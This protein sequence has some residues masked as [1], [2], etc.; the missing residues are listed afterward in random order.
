ML[1]CILY[2]QLLSTVGS[3]TSDVSGLHAKLDRKR[4]VE[5]HNSLVQEKFS[6]RFHDG[7]DD[8]SSRM[9]DF[10]AQQ[11]QFS[12]SLCNSFGNVVVLFCCIL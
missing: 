1:L 6:V 2:G 8:L 9:N 10:L 4:K 7:I 3:S 5:S 11:Q 12:M